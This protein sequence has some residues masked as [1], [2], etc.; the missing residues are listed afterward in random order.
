[1]RSAFLCKSVSID[2]P[3]NGDGPGDGLATDPERCVD[4]E[5]L[6]GAGEDQEVELDFSKKLD[7]WE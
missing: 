3:L 1:M 7:L 5:C 6:L 4:S 2:G